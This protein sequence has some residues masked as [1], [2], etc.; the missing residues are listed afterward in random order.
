MRIKA[1]LIG[2]AAAALTASAAW[3]GPQFV[4]PEG[5][6]DFG[7]DVVAYHTDFAAVKGSTAFTAEHNG[8]TFLFVSA[9]HRDLFAADPER[10]APAYD[11]H[12][13]YAL[14]RGKKLTVDPEAFSIVDP[15]TLAQVD[16]ATYTLE[17]GGVL[18][19]NYSPG[20][21]GKFNRDIPG[22]IAKADAEWVELEDDPAAAWK[23]SWRDFF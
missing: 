6:A 7:Y 10:F 5:Y 17:S 9:E 16:P 15:V 1:S 13:A 19:L 21:N 12:C 22:S 14:T 11:G 18:Y 20:V 8:A 3:A 2:A 23:K 4:G